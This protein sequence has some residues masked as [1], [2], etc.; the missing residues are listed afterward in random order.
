VI[1]RA[2]DASAEAETVVGMR[3][4]NR[5]TGFGKAWPFPDAMDFSAFH[6]LGQKSKFRLLRFRVN[7]QSMS[8]SPAPRHSFGE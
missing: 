1:V 3:S 7:S 8:T 4:A 5:S 6:R 2:T